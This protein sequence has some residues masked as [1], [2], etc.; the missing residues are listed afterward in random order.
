MTRRALTLA[1]LLAPGVAVLAISAAAAKPA[2]PAAPSRLVSWT[3]D[4]TL[5]VVAADAPPVFHAG[6]HDR[7]R[8]VYDA[9][10]V[11]SATGTVRIL[12]LQHW[13]DGHW[14]S[15]ASQPTS[16]QSILNVR[17]R[18]LDFQ[19]TVTHGA[20]ILIAL[21]PLNW[22]AVYSQKDGHEIIGGRYELDPAGPVPCD[23][24]I[25]ATTGECEARPLANP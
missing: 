25:W 20:P 23:A 2:H 19:R 10:Q 8:I 11:S 24:R 4:I 22:S 7:L 3:I 17:D 16:E 13:M 9:A 15:P 18:T 12:G 5:E 14:S 1:A 21:T 6:S